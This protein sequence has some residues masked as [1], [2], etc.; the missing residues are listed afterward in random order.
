[1]C[2]NELVR[3]GVGT[4][5][6][7]F[8]AGLLSLFASILLAGPVEAYCATGHQCP[9]GTCAPAGAD[10]CG[11]YGRD[12]YCSPG[13]KCHRNGGCCADGSVHTESGCL[14]RTSDRVCSNGTYCNAGYACIGG[15]NCLAVTSERYCGGRQYCDPGYVCAGNGKCRPVAAAAELP[16]GGSNDDSSGDVD[17]MQCIAV[18]G[19]GGTTYTIRNRCTYGVNIVLRTMDFSPKTTSDDRYYLS[20][21]GDISA[22][23]YH[24]FEPQVVRAC[25]KGQ[26][27]C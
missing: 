9:S 10:C 3:G 2:A 22:I 12:T 25:G 18:T 21:G 1:M 14:D 7:I 6:L 16:R 4:C 13:N 17:A 15:N 23:S 27:N 20:A 11:R 26:R 19:G 24:A 8:I 5:R